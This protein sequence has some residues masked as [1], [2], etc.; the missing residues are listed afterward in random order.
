MA[1]HRKPADVNEDTFDM[2]S[3]EQSQRSKNS[4]KMVDKTEEGLQ[5]FKMSSRSQMKKKAAG[6]NINKF[7]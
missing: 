7:E 3:N 2:R 4:K 6:L 1:S 5:L